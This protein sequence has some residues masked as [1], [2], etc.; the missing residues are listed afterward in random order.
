MKSLKTLLRI[1][2]RDLE[3]LRRALA[4]Q[5]AR[6]AAIEQSIV[7][8]AQSVADEQ[9]NAQGDYEAT[10]AYG[11]FAAHCVARRRALKS[12]LVLVGEIGDRLRA[13][14]AEAYVETRKFERLLELQAER[15]R[16]V[17]AK[18][19][20]AELDELATQRRAK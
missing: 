13:L 7:T 18:R 10:R 19:E 3:T 5:I 17:L 1:A 9:K 11:G 6:Q 4:E 16:A 12:E 15:E 20:A 8:L 2:R 14:I